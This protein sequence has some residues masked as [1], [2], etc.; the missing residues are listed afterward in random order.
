MP[1][2]PRAPGLEERVWAA[3]DRKESFRDIAARERV[4]QA[5][6]AKIKKQGR[7]EKNAATGAP[8]TPP[9]KQAAP[10][11][12]KQPAPEKTEPQKQAPPASNGSEGARFTLAEPDPPTGG[13][14][15][16]SEAP[17]KQAAP[18]ATEAPRERVWIV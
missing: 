14:K 2:L 3:L 16:A 11:A 12:S 18:A 7:P 15:G 9:E 5:T 17:K 8:A 6:V 13:R 4:S 1:R 10:A